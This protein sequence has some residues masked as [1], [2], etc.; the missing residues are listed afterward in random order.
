[1]CKFRPVGEKSLFACSV[2]PSE[3]TNRNMIA[4]TIFKFTRLKRYVSAFSLTLAHETHESNEMFASVYR[5][6][7]QFVNFI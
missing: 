7:T 2:A 6:F 1:M 3:M 4:E 5:R